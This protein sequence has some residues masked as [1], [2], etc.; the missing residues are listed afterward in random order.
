M[1]LNKMNQQESE[2]YVDL[3]MKKVLEDVE[4]RRLFRTE[5]Y[6]PSTNYETENNRFGRFITTN[7]NRSP[8]I[9]LLID[10]KGFTLIV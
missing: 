10:M 9:Y 2:P 4:Y 5:L 8:Y 6:G 3:K 1:I 7:G